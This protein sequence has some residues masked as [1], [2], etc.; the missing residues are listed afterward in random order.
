[1]DT[2]TAPSDPPCPVAHMGDVPVAGNDP[3]FYTHHANIDRMFALLGDQ[4][5]DTVRL[6]EHA[7]LQLP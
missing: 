4:V 5:R 1:M 3:V 7:D 2:Y 6:V